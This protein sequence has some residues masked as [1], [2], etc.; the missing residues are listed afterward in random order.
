M[1]TKTHGKKKQKRTKKKEKKKGGGGEEEEERPKSTS[2]SLPEVV[3]NSVLGV[4]NQPI[5]NPVIAH[6]FDMPLTT[7]DLQQ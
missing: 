6:A 7:T 1:E 3:I 2:S 5:L 4:T